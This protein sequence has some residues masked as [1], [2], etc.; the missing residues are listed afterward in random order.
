VPGRVVRE[1]TDRDRAT[2]AGTPAHYRER[3][4]RHRR[5]KWQDGP[6]R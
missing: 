5:A 3:A 2:F 4:E 6:T 1:L